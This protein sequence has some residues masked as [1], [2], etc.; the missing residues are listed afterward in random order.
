MWIV[1]SLQVLTLALLIWV[2]Y[3]NSANMFKLG[4]DNRGAYG[5][6]PTGRPGTRKPRSPRTSES[7]LT[8]SLPLG[9][10]GQP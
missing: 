6:K 3:L 4:R 7:S 2:T 8:G 9:D 5:R 10:G 1:I